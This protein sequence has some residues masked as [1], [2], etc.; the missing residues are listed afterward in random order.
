ML[1]SLQIEGSPLLSSGNFNPKTIGVFV[2]PR[3]SRLAEVLGR[4]MP[5][6]AERGIRVLFTEEQ[7][8]LL[9]P[10]APNAAAVPAES[11]G[12]A[13]DLVVAMGGDG[14]VL[15]AAR[16]IGPAEKP[17]F[18]VNLGSL[19]FLAEVPVE[20]L[21]PRMEAVLSGNCRIEKRMTLEVEAPASA[22]SRNRGGSRDQY[23]A[24]PIASR[25]PGA[26]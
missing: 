5:W 19:G 9:K 26:E 21:L 3:K 11:F 15:N 25:L 8:R 6:L 4:F 16:L 18:G 14:T 2:N 10:D 1:S 22:G 17:L 12:E 7:F 20:D 13:C 23:R 24:G